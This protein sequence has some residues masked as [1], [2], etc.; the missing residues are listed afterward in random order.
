VASVD[1]I[2]ALVQRLEASIVLGDIEVDDSSDIEGMRLSLDRKGNQALHMPLREMSVKEAA[3]FTAR[4]IASV[5]V[6][7]SVFRLHGGR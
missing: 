6:L 7:S 5:R 1:V 4:Y 2:K 3:R